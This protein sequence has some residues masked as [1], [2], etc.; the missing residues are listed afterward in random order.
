MP[1]PPPPSGSPLF[2]PSSLYRP[3]K[4][5]RRVGLAPFVAPLFGYCTGGPFAFESMIYSDAGTRKWGLLNLASGPVAYL[6]VRQRRSKATPQPDTV[7][8]WL[9]IARRVGCRLG[10]DGEFMLALVRT[11]TREEVKQEPVAR[12]SW[13]RLVRCGREASSAFATCHRV[14]SRIS[15]D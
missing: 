7:V 5:L 9:A 10:R 2:V 8:G 6:W 1:S 4:N 3:T 14:R 12:I 15:L 11:L 13:Q